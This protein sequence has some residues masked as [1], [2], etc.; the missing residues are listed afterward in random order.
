MYELIE[1]Y[2]VPTPPED[3]AVY[4]TLSPLVNAVRDGIDKAVGERDAK[5]DHFCNHMD[6]DIAELNKEVKSVKQES[7]VIFIELSRL[8]L[9]LNYFLY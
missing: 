8:I 2:S 6:K 4:Q 7:Q 5:I 3:F 1:K 9:E